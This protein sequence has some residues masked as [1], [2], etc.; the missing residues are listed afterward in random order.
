MS[1]RKIRK[2]VRLLLK[3]LGKEVLSAALRPRYRPIIRII[4]LVLSRR[5]REELPEDASGPEVVEAYTEMDSDDRKEADKSLDAL[6]DEP[7]TQQ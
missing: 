6:D 5:G 3:L 2:G 7:P 1:K 4:N